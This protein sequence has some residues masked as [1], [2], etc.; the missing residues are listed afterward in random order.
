MD[1]LSTHPF[2]AGMPGPWLERLSYQA[3][4][5]VR[6]AG[7]RMF[8]E[9]RPAD[10]FWLLRSGR[11]A[12]DLAVPGHGD[13]VIETI[14]AGSVLGWSWLFPPYRWHF[15]AVAVDQTSA[16][17]FTAAGV[18]RLIA[19]DAELGRELTTRFMAVLVDRLQAA[20]LR[21]F[22]LYDIAPSGPPTGDLRP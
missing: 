3:H 12:L 10:H 11:V 4:P 17:E 2:M 9:G 20:R 8:H 13:V 7:Q 14:E 5:V 15:G 18:R 22:Q 19:Q 1:V 6:H 16:V 21:L